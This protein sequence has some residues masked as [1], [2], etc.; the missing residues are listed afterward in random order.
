VTRAFG[1][2]CLAAFLG[3][4]LLALLAPAA[5]GAAPAVAT[6]TPLPAGELIAQPV[7]IGPVVDGRVDAAWAGAPTLR[8][9]LVWGARGTV[10]ALDVELRALRTTQA[11]YFLAQWRDAAPPVPAN[12]TANKLTLHW[13]LDAPAGSSPPA[14]NVACHT[15]YADG[16]GRLAYMHAETIPPGSDEALPAAGGWRNGLWTLEWSRPLIS[17]NP[18]DLQFTDL[19]RGYPFFVKIFERVEGRPDPVSATYRLVFRPVA[20]GPPATATRAAG[21]R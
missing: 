20:P 6:P 4:L 18:F 15:A 13:S 2:S 11:V 5:P 19:S 16:A 17:D 1:R 14:C 7:A 12:T 8:I 3:V 10:H 9:P 21:G